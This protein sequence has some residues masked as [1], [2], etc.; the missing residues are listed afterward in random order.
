M[1]R[2]DVI[3]Y[4]LD[5]HDQIV[6]VNEAWDSFA[7]TNDAPDLVA[8]CILHHSLWRFV[9]DPTLR[10]LY[11]TLFRQVRLGRTVRFSFRCDAPS[12][13][14]LLEMT[15]SPSGPGEIEIATRPLSVEDRPP[16]ALLDRSSPRSHSFLRACAWCN[17]IDL[18]SDD[19][20]EVELAI[21]RL[22]LFASH[23][24]PRVSHGICSECMHALLDAPSTPALQ[25]CNR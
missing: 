20:A 14:R 25:E 23:P 5:P 6:S 24:L 17:R 21:D 18:G 16:V 4:R 3:R 12:Q 7:R 8:P 13:R 9:S 19:W 10:Q 22:Q 11:Q 1:T 15:I 2:E